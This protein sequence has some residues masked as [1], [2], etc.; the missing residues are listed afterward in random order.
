ML[1]RLTSVVA[2]VLAT[3]LL[4]AGAQ[5]QDTLLQA[6]HAVNSGAQV[7]IARAAEAAPQPTWG[8]SQA[9]EDLVAL[10]S[11]AGEIAAA[12]E[13]GDSQVTPESLEAATT[14]LDV[15]RNRVKASLSLLGL[16]DA[17]T[18]GT[19][20]LQ[21]AAEL[22]TAL[23]QLD[24]RFLGRAQVHGAQLG[25]VTLAEAGQPMVYAN[26]ND[27]LREARGIRYSAERMLAGLPYN[28][29][30]CGPGGSPIGFGGSPFDYQDLRDLVRA[31][32]DFEFAVGN[33]YGDVEATR[34]AYLW[35]RR[36]YMRATPYWGGSY[37]NFAAWDLERALRRL[38][39]FYGQAV[40]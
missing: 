20:L 26:P 12:M 7:L 30:Y 8:Q 39:V 10:A 31:S 4:T 38:D 21:Q 22:S 3:L 16:D 6:A 32:Y 34:N 18:V 1:R 15:A 37:G 25:K 9:R 36:A 14:R 11:A 2:V 5:A 17:E 24:G 29:G 13:S 19:P 33:R 23:R 35:L 27:L 28:R 40:R